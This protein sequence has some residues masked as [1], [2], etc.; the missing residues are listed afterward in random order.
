LIFSALRA[1][2]APVFCVGIRSWAFCA[3]CMSSAAEHQERN[4]ELSGN[5]NRPLQEAETQRN[6]VTAVGWPEGRAKRVTESL[7]KG[8]S[9]MDAATDAMGQAC[10]WGDD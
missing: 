6:G 8:L 3:H 4:A 9:G 1:L 10:P 7:R 2:I 5:S